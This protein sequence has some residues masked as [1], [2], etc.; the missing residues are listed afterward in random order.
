MT[1][2]PRRMMPTLCSPPNNIDSAHVA[3][4]TNGNNDDITNSPSSAA[5]LVGCR[6][7]V[8]SRSERQQ[9]CVNNNRERCNRPLMSSTIVLNGNDNSN[10]THNGH[11]FGSRINNGGGRKP[12]NH[13]N[14]QYDCNNDDYFTNVNNGDRRYG[15][16]CDD[17][18]DS[19]GHGK[20]NN[21]HAGP[22]VLSSSSWPGMDRA[23]DDVDDDEVVDE[24]SDLIGI[25]LLNGHGGNSSGG[26]G[27]G[28]DVDEERNL[29]PTPLMS[30]DYNGYE[31][32]TPI[33]NIYDDGGGD[34]DGGNIFFPQQQQQ[35]HQPPPP[36]L[37]DDSNDDD[38]DDDI[39]CHDIKDCTNI[40][41]VQTMGDGSNKHSSN[42]NIIIPPPPLPTTVSDHDIVAYSPSSVGRGGSSCFSIPTYLHQLSQI[43]ITKI[44][45]HPLGHHV[46]LI[47]AEGLLFSYGSNRY[48]QLGIGNQQQH[49]QRQQQIHTTDDRNTNANNNNETTKAITDTN[50]GQ[51]KSTTMTMQQRQGDADYSYYQHGKPTI[52]T[53]LLENGGKTI[54][55][56]AGVDYSLVVVKT[57][58]VRIKYQQQQQQNHHH[59]ARTSRNHHRT[60]ASSSHKHQQQQQQ[61][62][63]REYHHQMYG[64]GNNH[65]RK[66]GLLNPDRE[67][68]SSSSSRQHH[69]TRGGSSSNINS[70][71]SSALLPGSPN[72]I[73]SLGDASCNTE[74]TT[75]SSSVNYYNSNNNNNNSNNNNNNNNNNTT[76]THDEFAD[77]VFLPRR[78]ALHCRVIHEKLPKSFNTSSVS[79]SSLT[80]EAAEA[81][82]IDSST[83]KF[84]PY[85]IFSIA[86]SVEHSS[87]LVKRP[88]GD[89]EIYTWGGGGIINMSLLPSTTAKK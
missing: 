13:D 50:H 28:D 39:N 81:V 22:V 64:F 58:C 76:T 40:I 1:T 79:S 83:S 8:K 32:P 53:P 52:V 31:P 10:Y 14:N 89:I 15:G 85:G 7:D 62:Q 26:G 9:S 44:S 69:T 30:F 42:S 29:S 82:E 34:S 77:C 12:S 11:N 38:D 49:H 75:G 86:A 55:C 84:P 2:T 59:R 3:K 68:S 56:A 80:E 63:Q 25:S 73:G 48:G 37:Y 78:V 67:A 71:R 72:S 5:T 54:N 24:L 17:V 27:R 87:A 65:D 51:R 45:A 36:D 66:L 6:C 20:N 16:S 46:L 47:S 61:Q 74:D 88:S 43:V 60:V 21:N 70:N 41:A 57:E 33:R 35:H 18:H 19:W 4:I 23:V